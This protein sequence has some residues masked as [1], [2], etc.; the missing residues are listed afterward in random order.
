MA[1]K[2]TEGAIAVK[3]KEVIDALILVEAVKRKLLKLLSV[4]SDLKSVDGN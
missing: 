2:K 1:D 3:K 4:E